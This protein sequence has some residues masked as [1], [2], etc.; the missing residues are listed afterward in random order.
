MHRVSLVWRFFS[1]R[2]PRFSWQAQVSHR[3]DSAVMAFSVPSGLLRTMAFARTR[4]ITLA[5]GYQMVP[6][7]SCRRSRR[8]AVEQLSWSMGTWS[9]SWSAGSRKTEWMRFCVPVSSTVA[10][11][12]WVL[13]TLR[14][15]YIC[16]DSWTLWDS[17]QLVTNSLVAELGFKVGM[18]FFREANG[19]QRTRVDSYV[20]S[21][22]VCFLY[23]SL[24]R[25]R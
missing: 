24:E 7:S 10:G 14:P 13:T 8:E 9:P 11:E 22:G 25:Y 4:C 1:I 19:A 15:K 23:L 21:E 6:C 18:L 2:P 3:C 16:L 20:S 17:G 12:F 5:T